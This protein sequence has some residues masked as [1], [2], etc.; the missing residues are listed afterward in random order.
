M[1]S[2]FSLSPCRKNSSMMS[3]AQRLQIAKGFIA[4]E[5]SPKWRNSFLI[6]F[7]ASGSVKI[8]TT[9]R[10]ADSICPVWYICSVMSNMSEFTSYSICSSFTMAKWWTLSVCRIAST[11]VCRTSR[12]FCLSNIP[13]AAVLGWLTIS[14]SFAQCMFSSGEWSLYRIASSWAVSRRKGLL[15]PGWPMSW[16]TALTI[17]AYLSW[18]L[19]NVSAAHRFRSRNTQWVTSTAWCQLWY[20][21]FAGF[22]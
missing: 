14:K 21:T 17:S 6:N 19:R 2:S 20:G 13:N 8:S 5:T 4:L 1:P 22:P 11:H 10:G 12:Y 18:V 7:L 3:Q 9:S 15:K 16:H